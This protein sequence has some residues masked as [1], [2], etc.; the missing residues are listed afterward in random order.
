[1][2]DNGEVDGNNSQ[3][4]PTGGGEDDASA[5]TFTVKRRM[6]RRLG[7][8]QDWAHGSTHTDAPTGGQLHR[9]DVRGHH[10]Q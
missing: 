1:M 10:Y 8:L 7:A 3:P 9:H 6:A 4:Q 5:S 2:P